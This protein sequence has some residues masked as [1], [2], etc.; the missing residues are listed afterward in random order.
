MYKNALLLSAC[1]LLFTTNLSFGNQ[2]TEWKISE[3]GNGHFYEAIAESN[4]L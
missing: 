1:S 4:R 3:G 2:P